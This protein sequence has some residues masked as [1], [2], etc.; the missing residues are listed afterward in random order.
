MTISLYAATVPSFLQHLRAL[1]GILAKAEAFCAAGTTAESDLLASRLVADMAPLGTQLKWARTH[2]LGA[3]NG[4][5]AGTFSP[6]MSEA[7][8]TLATHRANLAEAVAGLE[9]L[10]PA[11]VDALADSDVLF[12][13]PRMDMKLPFTGANFLFS[14]SLPNFFFH[15]TT[16]YDLLR[17]A[18]LDI[19]KRDYLGTMRLKG[20][21]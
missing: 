13:I 18:G 19:G 16:A 14:F 3:L 9:A 11:D 2:S 12:T 8:A 15:V 20:M 17:V 5:K 21:A 6:D 10:D 7:P 4:V 1:D